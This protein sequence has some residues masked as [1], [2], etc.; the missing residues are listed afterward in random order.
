MIASVRQRT[1]IHRYFVLTRLY[2]QSAGAAQRKLFVPQTHLAPFREIL[3][4]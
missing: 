4:K 1:N 2:E 3:L